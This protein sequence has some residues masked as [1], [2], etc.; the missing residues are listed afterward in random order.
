LIDGKNKRKKWRPAELEDQPWFPVWLRA[1][2]MTFL[3]TLDRLSN[4]YGPAARMIEA[5]N[6]NR[7]VDLASGSGQSALKATTTAR[8]RGAELLLTDK[9]PN[10]TFLKNKQLK[11]S[12]LDILN[13]EFP[14]AE[15]YS[16]FNAF[17]HF[18]AHQR[19]QIVIKATQNGGA[20]LVIEP[21]RPRIDI[22]FKVFFATFIGPFL[23]APFMR[24]FS[25]KWILLTY[26][27]P[28][29]VLATCYD[30]LAS[31]IKSLS[32]AEWNELENQLTANGK[33]VEQGLL[34]SRFAKL[35]YFL[36]K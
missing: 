3:A 5:E 14:A 16:M 19:A 7:I 1:Y 6:P 9:F 23:L 34:P 25:L 26:L 31:V 10:D 27:I 33:S 22:F 32:K 35:K 8:S 11:I 36:V 17:H 18:D 20:I 24:P 30:G 2:Q 4:L 21:L 13:D 28:I 15:L 12:H 29:G